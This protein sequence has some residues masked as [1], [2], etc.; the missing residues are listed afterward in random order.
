M[1]QTRPPSTG[2]SGHVAA[3][4]FLSRSQKRLTTINA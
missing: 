2:H 3:R 1:L 4:K